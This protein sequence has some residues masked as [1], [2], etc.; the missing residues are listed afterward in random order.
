MK[1][2]LTLLLC[3]PLLAAAAPDQTTAIAN[4]Q[5]QCRCVMDG[6]VCR[7]INDPN[8]PGP[9]SRTWTSEKPG[10]QISSAMYFAFRAQGPLMCDAGVEACAA[11]WDGEQCR[12]FR[13]MFN[14][15]PFV[16]NIPA[17]RK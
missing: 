6:G 3:S 4:M 2:L 10:A 11:G 12:A 15:K 16:C 7:V 5:S 17:V 14:D 8:P 1:R 13:L 9:T